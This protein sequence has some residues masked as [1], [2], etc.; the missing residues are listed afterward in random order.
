MKLTIIKNDKNDLL[1]RSEV[2]AEIDEK[3]IPSREEIRKNLSAKLNTKEEKIIIMKISS[4]FGQTKNIVQARIYDNEKD[5]EKNER[6]YM[7]KRNTP[8]KIEKKENNN[9]ESK[10][11]GE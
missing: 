2:I 3:K 10:E 6:K 11:K 5:L 4:K 1:S 7:I 8:K 9:E